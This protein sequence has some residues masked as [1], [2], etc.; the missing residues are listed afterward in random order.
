MSFT[1]NTQAVISGGASGLGAGVAEAILKQNGK[2]VIL[3]LKQPE[4][5]TIVEALGTSAHFIETD[6]ANEESVNAAVEK[7][8]HYLERCDL[9][10]S[11]AGVLGPGRVLGKNG[12]M[13]GAD[14]SRVIEINL[15]GAFLFTKA[16][17]D[18][19]QK[20]NPVEGEKGVIVHTASIA[21]YEGQFGQ[22]A[23]SAS[24]A[25]VMGMILP[26]A[27]EFAK[28]GVRIMALAPGMFDTAMLQG[29]SE[30][31][32]ADLCSGVPFPKRLGRADE[33]AS[34]VGQI[35][36]NQMLNG[37]VVRLDGAT[38]LQ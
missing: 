3:D 30:E 22:A 18:L 26:V 14:F 19:M 35:Y 27:R 7:A 5:P 8:G 33:F 34:M 37:S 12:P 24:K 29:I 1:E 15:V 2:V 16:I 31:A 28:Y 38:R 9:G 17:A 13:P 23:Y 21:G 36:Q 25:G 32:L 10:V 11:C 20:N 4:N 6:I